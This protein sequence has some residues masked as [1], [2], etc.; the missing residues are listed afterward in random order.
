[1]IASTVIPRPV[2][3]I[4]SMD[5]DG[6]LNAA[7]FS[8]FNAVSDDPPAIMVSFQRHGDGLFKDTPRNIRTRSEFVVNLVDYALVEKANLCA[9]A[10]PPEVSEP[11]LAGLET[12]PCEIVAIPRLV[13]SPISL[14]CRR[15]VGIDIGL[16]RF[17]EIGDVVGFHIHDDLIDAEKMH[18]AGERA[19]MIAR[20]HGADWYARTTDLFRLPRV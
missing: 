19:D 5:K 16:G 13:A 3:F 11:D 18:V 14:E 10:Q 6:V 1:M 4:T 8:F 15:R 20:M 7:P 17:I 2:A 9:S 12:A